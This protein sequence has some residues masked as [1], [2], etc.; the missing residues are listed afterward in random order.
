MQPGTRHHT[1]DHHILITMHTT[2]PTTT[3]ITTP[4]KY[5]HPFPHTPG[6]HQCTD[7]QSAVHAPASESLTYCTSSGSLPLLIPGRCSPLKVAIARSACSW[8]EKSTKP[9]SRERQQRRG[10]VML[11]LL[12]NT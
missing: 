3:P 8:L 2:S 6:P 5:R 4:Q 7:G 1:R 12:Y 9:N 11:L 10:R